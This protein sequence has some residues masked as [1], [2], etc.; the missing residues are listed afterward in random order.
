MSI[1]IWEPVRW[2]ITV[3]AGASFIEQITMLDSNGDPLP[4]E[5]YTAEMDFRVRYKDPTPLVRL[6]K[7]NGITLGSGGVITI[8]LT[9]SQTSLLGTTRDQTVVTSLEITSPTGF[10]I[11]VFDGEWV[12][13]PEATKGLI[14]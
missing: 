13:T 8:E 1:E 12:F 14:T 9:H 6:T 2:D 10:R 3:P 11:R 7:D 5:G 4:I